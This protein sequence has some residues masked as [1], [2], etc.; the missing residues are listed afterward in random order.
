MNE[1]TVTPPIDP[2]YQEQDVLRR[3]IKRQLPVKITD[4]YALAMSRQRTVVEGQLDEEVAEFAQA[5]D[6]HKAKVIKLED[7]IKRLRSII[8]SNHEDRPVLCVEVYRREE[9]N[10][11]FV[12]TYRTDTGERIEERSIT[13][14]E[15]QR[16]LPGVEGVAPSGG[17]IL[18]RVGS[19]QDNDEDDSDEEDEDDDGVEPTPAQKAARES[20]KA[21]KAR[22]KGKAK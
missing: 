13:I 15:A 9:G 22:Q 2:P 6:D 8:R 5:K 21:R 17:P 14:A 18:D 4:D 7:E 10:G 19:A 16:L 3:N 1:S 11:G 20:R 12:D